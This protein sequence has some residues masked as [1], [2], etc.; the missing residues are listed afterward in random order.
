[1]P[2]ARSMRDFL[3][4]NGLEAIQNSM[5]GA[6]YPAHWHNILIEWTSKGRI[7]RMSM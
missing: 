6:Y 3:V 2:I 5:L 7:R 4:E 1:M